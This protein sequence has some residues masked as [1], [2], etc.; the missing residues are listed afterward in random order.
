MVD[1]SALVQQMHETL[2]TIQ[3]TIADINN[4]EHDVILDGLEHERASNIAALLSSFQSEA[5]VLTR[6]RQD[7]R[8][9]IA[10]RRRKEDEEREA[11]RRKEDE[12]L[13]GKNEVEDSARQRLLEEERKR[14]DDKTDGM[15]DHVEEEARLKLEEGRK[16][17]T[18]LEGKRKVRERA[19]TSHKAVYQTLTLLT[20]DQPLN[21][22]TFV[23]TISSCSAP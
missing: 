22:R 14:I 1:V 13:A 16:I 9:A 5:D 6:K 23:D 18:E 3:A 4:A 20:G 11:K 21:R 19:A 8:D 10:E 17:L 7:E 15:M 12:E 2:S